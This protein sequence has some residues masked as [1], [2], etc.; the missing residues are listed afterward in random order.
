[1][2]RFIQI[3]AV[4]AVLPLLFACGSSKKVAETPKSPS[5]EIRE[6]AESAPKGVLRGY[7]SYNDTEEW[8]AYKSASAIARSNIAEVVSAK[9]LSAVEI[10]KG[11]YGKE[12]YDTEAVR[13]NDK[14][15]EKRDETYVK[16]IADE[17]LQGS[18]VVKSAVSKAANGTYDVYLCV[19]V[20]SDLVA[21]YI[22]NNSKIKELISEEEKLTIDFHREEFKKA[23][24][25]E[26]DKY[27]EERG[28]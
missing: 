9:V 24:Q 25:E 18:K 15:G 28:R 26:F 6:Y 22:S 20:D 23:L 19:E 5:Q 3:A 2:K 27:K 14:D 17:V 16:T 1:M 12:S 13:R 11:R 8:F 7:G 4:T 21:E 10:Y